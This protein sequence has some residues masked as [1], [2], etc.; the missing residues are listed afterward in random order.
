MENIEPLQ[1][2]TVQVPTHLLKDAQQIT[3]VGITQTIT[4]GLEKLAMS[5]AYQKLLTLKG[6]CK[7][8]IDVN[9]LRKDRD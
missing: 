7:L 2:I 6:A 1:K 5:A 9:S 4:T 3:G 8:D